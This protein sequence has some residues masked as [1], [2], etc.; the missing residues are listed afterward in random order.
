MA[1]V[2]VVDDD[3][4]VQGV[5]AMAAEDEGY[6]VHTAVGLEAV[7]VAQET[8]PDLILLDVNIPGADGIEVAWR[9]RQD[10]RTRDI[11]IVLMSAGFNLRERARDAP[12]TALLSKP[13]ELDAVVE[14]LHQLAGK[15][16]P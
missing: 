2:L 9:L 3:P 10:Q 16:V 15:P 6:E 4:A 8:H 11:P 5:L 7:T 14:C 12:V 13:F 1:R